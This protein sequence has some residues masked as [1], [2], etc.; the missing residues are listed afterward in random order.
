MFWGLLATQFC[1]LA[2]P[3]SLHHFGEAV[4][5]DVEEASNEQPKDSAKGGKQDG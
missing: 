4:N 1:A 3:F 5:D 2:L